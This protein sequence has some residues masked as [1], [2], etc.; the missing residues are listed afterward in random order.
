[1][2]ANPPD[3]PGYRVITL[4]GNDD[5]DSQLLTDARNDGFELEQFFANDTR[6]LFE[7]YKGK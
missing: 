2:S 7:N 1:M 5:T 6:V 4:T 3:K